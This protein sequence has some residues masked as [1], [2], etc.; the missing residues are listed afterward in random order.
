MLGCGITCA[1]LF[2]GIWGLWAATNPNP[3]QTFW[4]DRTGMIHHEGHTFTCFHGQ[5]V[6]WRKMARTGQKGLGK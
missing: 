4:H 6:G 1:V 2:F 5:I 3:C